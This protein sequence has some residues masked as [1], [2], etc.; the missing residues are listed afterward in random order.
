MKY[1]LISDL[2]ANLEALRAVLEQIEACGADK[3]VCLGDVVGY[4]ANPNECVDL[5]RE[6]EIP[7]VCGNHDAVAS[8]LDEP[9]GFNPIALAAALWT[10]ERLTEENRLWLRQLPD[11]LSL[12]EF[13]AVHGSPNDRDSYLFTWEDIVPHLGHLH[14]RGHS[15]C[16]FGHTHSPCVFSSG[17]LYAVENGD[18]FRLRREETFFVNPGSVGQPRDGNP[19]AAFGLLDT[20]KRQFSMVRVEYPVESASR[21]IIKAGLPNF[22][23]ER[24]FLGR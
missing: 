6:R 10:R 14:E 7:T 15:L 9:W 17:G 1:A 5:I 8:G 4:N 21:S 13:L 3:T 11:T 20:E 12:T 24:L 22:L 19:M 2:H 18:I 23:A 16:F